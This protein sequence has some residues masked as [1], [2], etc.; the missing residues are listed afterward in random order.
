MAAGNSIPNYLTKFTHFPDELGSVVI[1][2]AEDDIVSL[3][4]LG[5]L[6]SWHSYQDSINGREK[7]SDWE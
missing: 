6:M 3:V 4:L 2:V 7:L 1:I 5:L